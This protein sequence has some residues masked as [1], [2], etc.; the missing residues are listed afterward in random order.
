[1][2][3]NKELAPLQLAAALA[4]AR[5]RQYSSARRDDPPAHLIATS[6]RANFQDVISDIGVTR[7]PEFDGAL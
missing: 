5:N 6:T 3:T 4:D 7:S 1:M 2:T